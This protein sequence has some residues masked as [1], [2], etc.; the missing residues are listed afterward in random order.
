MFSSRVLAAAG[1][2]M[3]AACTPVVMK[4]PVS[5][6]A[7]ATA[8][9][10]GDWHGDYSSIESGRRGLIA[11]RLNAGADTADGDVIMQAG[12]E[13]EPSAPNASTSWDALRTTHQP[14]SIRFVF[15]S[16]DEVSGALDPY[17]DPTCGCTLTTTFRGTL[18]GDV[19]EG[20]FRSEGSGFHHL[21]QSGRWRV[22]RSA[23]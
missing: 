18:R 1:A 3:A 9:L 19:I 13:G 2:L 11:F 12:D 17:R 5:G 16:N 6:T 15:V 14:L 20:T 8:R 21:P 23:R 4:T 10:V 7:S 22:K